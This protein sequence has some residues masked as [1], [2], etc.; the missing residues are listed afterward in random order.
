MVEGDDSDS[1]ESLYV[2]PMSTARAGIFLRFTFWIFRG[3]FTTYI[4]WNLWEVSYGK[5][6]ERLLTFGPLFVALR[7]KGWGKEPSTGP[8]GRPVEKD[9]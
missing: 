8:N 4:P 2:D 6:G 3:T 9:S 7:P 1:D 5:Y